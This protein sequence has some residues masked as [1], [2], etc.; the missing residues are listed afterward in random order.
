MGCDEV[1][2]FVLGYTGASDD[3][4][5]VYV[6]FE[7]ALFTRLEA[8]GA[9][10][11]T[12]VRRVEDV[13]VF[14]LASRGETVDEAVNYFVDG[15]KSTEARAVEVV[16]EVDVGLVLLWKPRYPGYTVRLIE[17]QQNVEKGYSNMFTS[18]GLK[19]GFRG[20][21]TSSKRCLCLVAGIGG[22]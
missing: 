1:C 14:Q 17:C 9:N 10:M 6:V 12:V 15:L 20:T 22:D 13:R 18:L 21:M 16:V 19:L 7:G 5:D 8:V 11:V 3:E 2:G 4:R